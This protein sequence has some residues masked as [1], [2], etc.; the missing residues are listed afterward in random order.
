MNRSSLFSRTF[1]P[2]LALAALLLT[3][4]RAD[5][6]S[7][8]P[9]SLQGGYTFISFK[10]IQNGQ[11][12]SGS[13]GLP[14]NKIQIGAPG[15]A[16][17]NVIASVVKDLGLVLKFTG[18]KTSATSYVASFTGTNPNSGPG[19]T[20]TFRAGSILQATL[21]A[22]GLTVIMKY[23]GVSISKTNFSGTITLVL[24]KKA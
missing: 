20:R 22:S 9:K 6:A 13:T 18:A 8:L 21:T 16:G 14:T 17:S 7:T 11:P 5:A 24:K 3:G 1:L 2:F 23:T 15:L 4:T 12:H 10:N 19:S